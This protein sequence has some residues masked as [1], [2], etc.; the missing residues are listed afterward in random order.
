MMDDSVL[1]KNSEQKE[2]E[3][4]MFLINSILCMQIHS[5]CNMEHIL[6]LYKESD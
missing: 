1:L 2:G 4:C 3:L 6:F 5:G